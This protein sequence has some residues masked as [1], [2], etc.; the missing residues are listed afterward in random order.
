MEGAAFA[1]P[2]HSRVPTMPI[3]Y[4]SALR[5]V[6]MSTLFFLPDEKK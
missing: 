4:R 2:H 1:A 6:F 5:H 3:A